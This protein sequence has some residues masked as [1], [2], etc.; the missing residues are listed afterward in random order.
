MRALI[1]YAS[2]SGASRECAELLWSRL[3]DCSICDMTKDLPD[4]GPF[5]T[6]I[7][8][9]GIRMG[10]LYRPVRSFMRRNMNLLLSKNLAFYLCNAY[11]GTLQKTIET[12]I[13]KPL[14]ER[15]VCMV[16]FG[17]KPPFTS[18][19]NQEWVQMDSVA[20]FVKAVSAAE[21]K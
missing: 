21:Q 16:S 10:K 17:G 9:S 15:A 4:L 13:P 11:P 6:L 5:D 12:S 1:L 20:F 8:G 3:E 2:K 18:P 14:R 7:L 19:K